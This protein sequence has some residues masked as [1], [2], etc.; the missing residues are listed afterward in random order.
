MIRRMP[1][2]LM[3][4]YREKGFYPPLPGD[5]GDIIQVGDRIRRSISA[6]PLRMKVKSSGLKT[7]T[8]VYIHPQK[9]FFMVEFQTTRGGKPETI[10]ESYDCYIDDTLVYYE[11]LK[12][13][14]SR[15]YSDYPMHELESEHLSI[16]LNESPERIPACK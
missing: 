1:P 9:R 15:E 16:I 2:E 12:F 4:A 8:I 10:R 7:G 6:G 5:L 11:N 13:K 3:E 14:I